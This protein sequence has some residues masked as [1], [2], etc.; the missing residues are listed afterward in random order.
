VIK[1]ASRCAAVVVAGSALTLAVG[2]L[3]AQ[4]ATTGWR[5]ETT[6]AVRGSETLFAGVAASSPADAWATGFSAKDKGTSSPKPLIRHWTGKAWRSVTLPAKVA[7]AWANVAPVDALVGAASAR[8]VWVFGSFTGSYLRLSGSRWSLGQLPGVS[9][10]SGALVLIDAVKVINGTNVW[11]FGER[12][13]VSGSQ[14]VS[15]PYAAHYNGHKW[16]KVTVPGTGAITAVA[17]VSSS[18]I[19]AVESGESSS[20]LS[21]AAANSGLV[22]SP[23]ARLAAAAPAAA[24]PVVLQ[25]TPSAGWHKAAQQPTLAVTDLLVSAVAEPGGEVWFGGSADN[26]AKGASPLTAEWNGT[27]WAVTD[28]PGKA[29][30][31]DWQLASMA[32]DGTGGIWA[33]AANE[34]TGAER[35]WHLHG[36]TWSQFSPAFG[37][38]RWI[39]EA[40]ALVPG[41][42]SVWAVGTVRAGK[43]GANGLIAVDGPLPR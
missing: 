26:S 37:K 15:A 36:T 43:S 14:E 39:L 25:W 31:A 27:S 23:A 41:T 8:S 18:D 10:K 16:A 38:R 20:V 28:L 17:A 34:I 11:A 32:P 3:P 9:E 33:L 5:I 6:V 30:S 12:D 35:I 22:R 1:L 13:S 42:H 7:R 29:S 24:P 40:L 19:W 2:L 21:S 4:A